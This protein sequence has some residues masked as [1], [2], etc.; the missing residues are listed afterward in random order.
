MT[1]VLDDVLGPIEGDLGLPPMSTVI[2]DLEM[3][4]MVSFGFLVSVKMIEY[5]FE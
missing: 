1:S 2:Q 5:A 4:L 3:L